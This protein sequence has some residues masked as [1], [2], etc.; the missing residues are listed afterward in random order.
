MIIS[1]Q[2]WLGKIDLHQYQL[3]RMY[4]FLEF[5]IFVFSSEE[6]N[7]R[8]ELSLTNSY[9]RKVQDDKEQGAL[10]GNWSHSLNFLFKDTWTKIRLP[11][12]SATW[13]LTTICVRCH[14][15]I[16]NHINQRSM[17]FILSK[18]HT[19]SYLQT[20]QIL[21]YKNINIFLLLYF[22]LTNLHPEKIKKVHV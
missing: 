18:K 3:L 12:S 17:P 8:F 20:M 14:D 1:I 13:I 15:L 10:E 9:Q 5:E 6:K 19:N 16:C 4:V 21:L 2:D 22:L 7:V 11:L